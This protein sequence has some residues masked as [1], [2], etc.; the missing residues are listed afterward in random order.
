MDCESLGLKTAFAAIELDGSDK[1]FQAR[2]KKVFKHPSAAALKGSSGTLCA[3]S[4]PASLAALLTRS[5]QSTRSTRGL[6]TFAS[7]PRTPADPLLR[8]YWN[9]GVMTETIVHVLRYAFDVLRLGSIIVDPIVGNEASLRLAKTVGGQFVTTQKNAYLR[10]IQQDIYKIPRGAWYEAEKGR[11]GGTKEE[12]KED[13]DAKN[14]RWCV[15]FFFFG[16]FGADGRVRRCMRA[17]SNALI[18]CTRCDWAWYC[19]VE[20]R[21]AD[22]IY[23]RGH[24]QECSLK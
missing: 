12:P 16:C 15:P 13:K 1:Q 9:Q 2:S 22:A 6:P 11:E 8:S 7:S 4:L 21:N 3:F 19:T 18:Q 24:T 5:Q 10:T 14:C 23:S 17:D 20:C